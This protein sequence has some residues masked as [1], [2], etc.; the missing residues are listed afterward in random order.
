MTGTV[1]G[2]DRLVTVSE[3]QHELQPVY[4]T[5]GGELQT[6][7]EE[8]QASNE[9]LV[10]VNEEMENRNAELSHNDLTNLFSN[11]NIPIVMVGK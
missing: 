8:L 9:E 11:V 7:K 3:L 10:T 6:S 5:Y 2:V 4:E 1:D